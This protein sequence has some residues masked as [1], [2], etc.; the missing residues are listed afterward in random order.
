MTQLAEPSAHVADEPKPYRAGF[1]FWHELV[2]LTL[3]GALL[4]Y[5]GVTE[6]RF[7]EIL[8]SLITPAQHARIGAALAPILS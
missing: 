6:P 2:L 4:A 8:T 3:L 7:G 1:P 5:A